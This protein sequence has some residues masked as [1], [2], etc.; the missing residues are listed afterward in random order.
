VCDK[1][2]LQL[3]SARPAANVLIRVSTPHFKVNYV[4]TQADTPVDADGSR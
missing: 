1:D 4:H 3:L 2:V